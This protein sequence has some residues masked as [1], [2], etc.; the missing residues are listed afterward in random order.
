MQKEEPVNGPVI[1]MKIL[2]FNVIHMEMLIVLSIKNYSQGLNKNNY[3][4]RKS[5]V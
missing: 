1:Q 2:E 4:D 5:V 3:L